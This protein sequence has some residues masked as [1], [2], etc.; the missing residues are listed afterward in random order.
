MGL[1]FVEGTPAFLGGLHKRHT[2]IIAPHL[3]AGSSCQPGFHS[4][5][6]SIILFSAN[7]LEQWNLDQSPGQ[8]KG[9]LLLFSVFIVI[10]VAITIIITT[11][12]VII[13]IYCSFVKLV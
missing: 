1:S 5:L 2:Q 6:G 10:I 3:D 13:M 4:A 11:I 9:V 7:V 8:A 12:I